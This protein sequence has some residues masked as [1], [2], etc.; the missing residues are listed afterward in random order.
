MLGI[1]KKGFCLMVLLALMAG[2]LWAASGRV[3][4][5]DGSPAVGAEVIVTGAGEKRSVAVCD[6][7]GRFV[8]DAVPG[9]N[10]VVRIRAA[11]KGYAQVRLPAG[12]FA[13]GDLAIVLPE[14]PNQKKK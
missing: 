4:Y 1:L 10:A 13:S 12:V 11:G 8:L 3:Q 14:K 6:A 2:D 5:Q 9:E 7:Q